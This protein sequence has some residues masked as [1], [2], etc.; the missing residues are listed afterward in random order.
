MGGED[1][2][3][4]RGAKGLRER[5]NA[6]VQLSVGRKDEEGRLEDRQKESG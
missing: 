1:C 3:E 2:D 6:N 4:K 5:E